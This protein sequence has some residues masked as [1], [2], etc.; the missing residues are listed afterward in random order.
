MVSTDDRAFLV[1]KYAAAVAFDE[2][3]S[4]HTTMRVGGPADVLFYP[5]DTVMFTNILVWAKDRGLPVTVL[6]AGSNVIVGDA[7]IRGI[8]LKLTRGFD[9]ICIAQK[10]KDH[11]IVSA[12]A[13]ARLPSLV[14]FAIDH[15][16]EGLN[17]AVGIPGT[18]GGAVRM[19][20]GTQSGCM[21]DIIERINLFLPTFEVTDQQ[22]NELNFSYRGVEMIPKSIILQAYMRLGLGS[23]DAL[24]KAARA[25]LEKR[26]VRQ[27]YNEASAGSIFKNPA[28]G[29]AAGE[30]IEKAGLKGVCIND[31]QVSEKHANFI[32]N[33]DKA[34]GSDVINLLH[35]VQQ[36]VFNKSGVMLEPE[37]MIFGSQNPA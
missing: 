17:F 9:G 18:V 2:P 33:R 8:V 19:N 21:A 16:F 37:V 13:G 22:R 1:K 11:V 32:V 29:P 36:T 3:M 6:G 23:A 20:A 14:T 31:A 28:T 35:L 25:E 34:S 5:K 24:R 26:Q 12:G 4:R 15:G 10:H 27:P 30:L 7:G